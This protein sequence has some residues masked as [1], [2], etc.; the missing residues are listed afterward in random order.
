MT[1]PQPDAYRIGQNCQDGRTKARQKLSPGRM[2]VVSPVREPREFKCLELTC[3]GRF[4]RYGRF[5]RSQHHWLPF[6]RICAKA[7][8]NWRYEMHTHTQ[9]EMY[10][11]LPDNLQIIYAVKWFH[12]KNESGQSIRIET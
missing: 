5:C 3:I 9:K 2:V 1:Q 4:M 11:L 10:Q 6:C 7:F 12:T 8:N